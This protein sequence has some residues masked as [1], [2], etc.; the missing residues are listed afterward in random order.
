MCPQRTLAWE[1][2]KTCPFYECPTCPSD[3]YL[4]WMVS[5]CIHCWLLTTSE[6]PV[7]FS[8]ALL[9]DLVGLHLVLGCR[10]CSKKAVA[11]P[12]PLHGPLLGEPLRDM[13]A[14]L[15]QRLILW[16]QALGTCS[17]FLDAL[18]L[19]LAI[20]SQTPSPWRPWRGRLRHVC[21]KG[22]GLAVAD[23]S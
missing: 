19:L 16:R 21:D 18:Q 6:G 8:L 9:P 10:V 12:L 2:G 23:P 17:V 3:H 4:T 1:V 15:I 7:A 13:G 11:R 5:L 22:Q 14:V 20:T